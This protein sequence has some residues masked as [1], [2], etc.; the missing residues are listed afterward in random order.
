MAPPAC[1]SRSC[2][3]RTGGYIPGNRTTELCRGERPPTVNPNADYYALLGEG[4]AADFQA[5]KRAYYRRAKQCHPD[6][7]GG[8]AGKEEEFKRLVEAFNVLSD[9]LQRQRYDASYRSRMAGADGGLGPAGLGLAFAE[10]E[11]A[12]LDTFADDALEELIVGNTIPQG[13]TLQTLMLDLERT[14]KFCLFRE[15]KTLFY[16]GDTSGAARL[17]SRYVDT[18]PINVLGR[19][20]LGKCLA[21]SGQGRLA[22]EHFLAA[23]RLGDA[24]QPPL[25]LNRIRREL[26]IVRRNDRGLLTRV[27]HLFSPPP[28]AL[29][30]ASPEESLRRAVSRQMDR[31]HIEQS[32]RR[33]LLKD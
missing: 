25:R 18:S 32:R 10:D 28:P 16:R 13:T 2:R 7:F 21:Q 24:R 15:A 1:A 29:P 23:L 17:F 12:I 20:Y 22:E 4:I 19:Y 27:R 31:L 3:P 6:L 11:G 5:I 26:A 8:D 9:P 30:E 14:E 33:R